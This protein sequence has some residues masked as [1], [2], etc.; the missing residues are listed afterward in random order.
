LENVAE[1]ATNVATG[2]PDRSVTMRRVNSLVRLAMWRLGLVVIEPWADAGE[3]NCLLHYARGKRRLAEIGVWEGGTTKR[4]R[5]AMDPGGVLFAIDPF[6][7]GRLGLSY[8]RPI[9]HGEVARV[10]N[11]EV[12]WIRKRGAEAAA[13]PRVRTAQFDFV[14]I[15]GDHSFAGLQADWQAWEPLIG[16]VVALH[17]AAGDPEQGS[18]RYAREVIFP[19]PRFRLLETQGCL[20]VLQRVSAKQA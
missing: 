2:A 20:V 10:S 15:D 13:D 17:D 11:G 19:D 3:T 5:A 18:E 1:R 8:Q 12:V 14:F 16:D 7:V 6:P 4:L 9:A